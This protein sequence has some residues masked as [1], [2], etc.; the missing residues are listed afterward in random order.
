MMYPM[1]TVEPTYKMIL[2]VVKALLGEDAPAKAVLAAI[3]AMEDTITEAEERRKTDAAA[4]ETIRP[5]LEKP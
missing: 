5:W 3:G 1:P 4:I 2:V